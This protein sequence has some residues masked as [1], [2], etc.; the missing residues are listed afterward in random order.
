MVGNFRDRP[1]VRSNGVK[2]DGTRLMEPDGTKSVG[3]VPK[4]CGD[5]TKIMWDRYLF[6][7][8]EHI[9]SAR[10]SKTGHL[11]LW[12]DCGLVR[13]IHATKLVYFCCR[14]WPLGI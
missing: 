4:L 11:C 14:A 13:L 3:T 5:G 10:G 12:T 9:R 6:F 1:S 8:R 7:F 2:I